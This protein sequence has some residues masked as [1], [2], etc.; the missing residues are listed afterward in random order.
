MFALRSLRDEHAAADVVQRVLL[1]TLERL[2][3]GGVREPERLASFVLG[4]CRMTLGDGAKYAKRTERV[5][6][7]Y[8]RSLP[9]TV[10][11]A[12]DP[13]DRARLADCLARL[14]E[15]ERSVVVMTFFVERTTDEIVEDLALTPANVRVI[16]HRA[17]A[18]LRGCMEGTP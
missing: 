8:A 14:G 4:V 2:R 11:P 10:A 13:I 6:D 1:V 16:R 7:E 12:T 3:T 18:R 15:R 5:L 9:D 17:L